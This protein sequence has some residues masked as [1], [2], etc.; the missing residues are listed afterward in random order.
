MVQTK[1]SGRQYWAFT[2]G[3]WGRGPSIRE[4][5]RGAKA[6]YYLREPSKHSVRVFRLPDW[7]EQVE[8]S[9]LTGDFY[10]KAPEE[11]L[12]AATADAEKQ[13]WYARDGNHAVRVGEWKVRTPVKDVPEFED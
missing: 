11:M 4:A 2:L 6:N 5:F 7:A 3:A 9:E 1:T 8:F 13:E 12:P 10:V